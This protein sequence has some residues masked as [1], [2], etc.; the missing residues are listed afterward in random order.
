MNRLFIAIGV[1]LV[2]AT[3]APAPASADHDIAPPD[4]LAQARQAVERAV[5]TS[6]AASEAECKA[7]HAWER[8]QRK[9]KPKH[10]R[11]ARKAERRAQEKRAIANQAVWQSQQIAQRAVRRTTRELRRATRWGQHCDLAQLQGRQRRA[12]RIYQRSLHAPRE[13]SQQVRRSCEH[14]GG[15]GSPVIV[16]PRPY[17]PVVDQPRPWP[18]VVNHPRPWPPVV[19][20]PRPVP[21]VVNRPRPW[22]P[23]PFRVPPAPL[24]T[25]G[26][27]HG[28]G[29]SHGCGIGR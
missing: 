22:R 10:L 6:V 15:H 14:C 9:P 3:L 29:C 21:P 2:A 1:G 17:P 5:A 18:P 4:I 13:A 8:Y 11:R 19:H 16:P 20:K 27:T 7:R 28:Q 12:Q 24:P 26:H 25:P 23:G